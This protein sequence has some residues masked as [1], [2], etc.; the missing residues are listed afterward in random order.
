MTGTDIREALR[1]IG[2]DVDVPAVDPVGFHGRVRQVRRRRT[3]MRAGV[4]VLAFAVVAGIGVAVLAPRSD[5]DLPPSD[6]P[7]KSAVDLSWNNTDLVMGLRE[8]LALVSPGDAAGLQELDLP[9]ARL[10]EEHGPFLTY[11]DPDG[12][13]RMALVN[14]RGRVFTDGVGQNPRVYGPVVRA[15]AARGGGAVAY[16]DPDGATYVW[17]NTADDPTEIPLGSAPEVATVAVHGDGEVLFVSAEGRTLSI[18]ALGGDTTSVEAAAEITDIDVGDH[19]MSVQ[20][21]SGVEIRDLDGGLRFPASGTHSGA[22]SDDGHWYAA[23]SDRTDLADGPAPAVRLLN[24]NS[25]ALEKFL[26]PA[27]G[28]VTDVWWQD[29]D[30][31]IMMVGSAATSGRRLLVCTVSAWSCD[32]ANVN[33]QTATMRLPQ[34]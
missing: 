33:D 8:G 18:T 17:P 26:V 31:F 4:G 7:A 16:V 12:M 14:S 22:L 27:I 1:T 6:G 15:W 19:T 11:L 20:T 3:A 23:V 13:V 28:P 30:R 5:R 9:S 21:T 29:E 24:T 2:E 32:L 25:G 10:L 34:D